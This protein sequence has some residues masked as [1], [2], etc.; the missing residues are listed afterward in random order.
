MN[1]TKSKWIDGPDHITAPVG[2]TWFLVSHSHALKSWT[3]YELRDSPPKT[4]QSFEDTPIGWCGTYNDVATY[5]RGVWRVVRVAKN[6]RVQLARVTDRA[7]IAA[8]LDEIGFP[9]LVDECIPDAET[10]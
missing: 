10:A 1:T 2:S 7:E 8:Y 4:N 9:D 6:G 3:R 5:G